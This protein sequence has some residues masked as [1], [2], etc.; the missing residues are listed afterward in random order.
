[1]LSDAAAARARE[2]IEYRVAHKPEN[3][4]NAR[5]VRNLLEHAIAN[6]ATRVVSLGKKKP[7]KKLLSTL[8]AEDL[9][10]WQ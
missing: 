3:F 6:H 5:D 10:D 9:E 2:L 8:E 1:V 4:A 7:T